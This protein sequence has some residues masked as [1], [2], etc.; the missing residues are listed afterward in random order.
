MHRTLIT[1]VFTA[2]IGIAG[3]FHATAP[4][5]AVQ[6]PVK[7]SS[8]GICHCPGGDYYEK[9]SNFSPYPS[10]DSC[11]AEGGRHPS[12]GQ[13]QC[14]Q[15][16]A[17]SSSTPSDGTQY[18]S[19]ARQPYDRDL[20]GGWAD[21]D[22]DCMNTRHELLAELSTGRITT[23]RDGCYVQHGRWNDPYTGR[24]YNTARDLDVDHLVPLAYAW[25]RGADSWS[26]EKRVKFANDPANLF[27]VQASANR[28]KGADGPLDWMPPNQAFHCQ[29]LLRFTRVSLSYELQFSQSEA[30]AIDRMTRDACGS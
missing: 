26:S 24:I 22:G 13:G 6:L 1:A 28:Q 23:S 12:R 20:F 14:T 7:K 5:L 15:A 18:A 2:A 10:I 3:I 11:I 30:L 25:S 9:T 4:A 29:Y 27:A 16:S 17:Q 21:F 19:I 8:S